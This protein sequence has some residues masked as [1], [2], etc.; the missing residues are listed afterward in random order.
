M[1]LAYKRWYTSKSKLN[2]IINV[3]VCKESTFHIQSIANVLALY[4]LPC[5]LGIGCWKTHIDWALTL[6]LISYNSLKKSVLHLLSRER[7]PWGYPY[8]NQW[9]CWSKWLKFRRSIGT[10]NKKISLITN[11]NAPGSPSQQLKRNSEINITFVP[12]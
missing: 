4:Q 8:T 5:S 1:I 10:K 12:W 9:L 7:H 3:N 11:I 6:S 2:K